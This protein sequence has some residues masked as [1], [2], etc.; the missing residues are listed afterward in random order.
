M[1][2]YVKRCIRWAILTIS[3]AIVA[4]I[5]MLLLVFSVIPAGTYRMIAAI[6]GVIVVSF[7][8]LL[9]GSVMGMYRSIKWYRDDPSIRDTVKRE[10]IARMP[11]ELAKA[12]G[13]AA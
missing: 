3:A 2:H 1:N 12:L 10:C 9:I 11:P 13:C 6:I 4:N 7:G 5:A 8:T